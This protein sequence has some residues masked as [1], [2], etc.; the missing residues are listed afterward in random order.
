MKKLKNNFSRFKKST[1]NNSIIKNSVVEFNGNRNNK[2]NLSPNK[3]DN[4][5]IKDDE[6]DSD[7][8]NDE[9][10][11]DD[12]DLSN[13]NLSRHESD[14]LSNQLLQSEKLLLSISS[15]KDVNLKENVN[16]IILN[17]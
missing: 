4:K 7:D 2:R 8:E 5:R 10:M 3:D 6:T 12:E 16:Q 11:D 14:D 15:Y 13:T 17:W 1:I 9:D